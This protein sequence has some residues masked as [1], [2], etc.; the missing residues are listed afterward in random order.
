MSVRVGKPPEFERAHLRK[1]LTQTECRTQAQT[2]GATSLFRSE[3]EVRLAL[4]DCYSTRFKSGRD[5]C[6]RLPANEVE[7]AGI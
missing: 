7:E 4:I 5:V 6:S 2:T 3:R 1:S